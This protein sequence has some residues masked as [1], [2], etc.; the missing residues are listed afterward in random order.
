MDK[1]PRIKRDSPKFFAIVDYETPDLSP[2]LSHAASPSL[3]P[4]LKESSLKELLMLLKFIKNYDTG[5]SCLHF[6]RAYF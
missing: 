4:I 1:P 3:N 2:P 5:F 6:P